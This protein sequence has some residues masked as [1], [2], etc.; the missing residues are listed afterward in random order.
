MTTI[1]YCDLCNK[2][3]NKNPDYSVTLYD[4]IQDEDIFE[5]DC[6]EECMK[7]IRKSIYRIKME[8]EK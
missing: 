2:D 4:G 6:C 1:K 5:W 3:L 7:K 8:V